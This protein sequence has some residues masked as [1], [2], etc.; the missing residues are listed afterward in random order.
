MEVIDCLRDCAKA[1]LPLSARSLK[2][3]EETPMTKVFNR[4]KYTQARGPYVTYPYCAAPIRP[5][6]MER[7]AT[8]PAYVNSRQTCA[9]KLDAARYQSDL[10]MSIRP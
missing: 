2:T 5:L 8:G 6:G 7:P 10:T 3:V 4:I 1:T 9:Q